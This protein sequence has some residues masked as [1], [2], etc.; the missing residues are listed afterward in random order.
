MH[1]SVLLFESI[2]QLVADRRGTYID[3]TFGGGGH[4]LHLLKSLAPKS[5]LLSLDWDARINFNKT[6]DPRL[7]CFSSNF[8][9]LDLALEQQSVAEGEVDGMLLDLGMSQSQL[10]E[11]GFGVG[12]EGFLSGQKDP[13]RL[14]KS[15]EVPLLSNIIKTFSNEKQHHHLA[16][17]IVANSSNIFTVRDVAAIIRK[18]KI[19]AKPSSKHPATKTFQAIRIYMNQEDK[20][21]EVLL[22]KSERVL[23]RDGKLVIITFHSLEDRIVQSFLTNT[24]SL[25]LNRKIVP[26]EIEVQNNRSARSA[27]AFIIQKTK[28]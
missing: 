7:F 8:R 22:R 13:L 18:A 6:K 28:P 12:T 16:R 1:N 4:S 23:K 27:K 26:S 11:W 21:L 3:G 24:R 9:D 10:G 20:N 14:L 5:R 25:Q 19:K 15:L 17:T 2:D